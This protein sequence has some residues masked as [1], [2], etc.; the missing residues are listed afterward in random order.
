MVKSNR[1]IRSYYIA[2]AGEQQNKFCSKLHYNGSNIF[3]FVNGVKIYK[4]KCSKLNAYPLCMCNISKSF[5]VDN[6]VKMLECVFQ[7]K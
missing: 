6:M 7:I 2:E 5:T 1:W 3:L 4:F